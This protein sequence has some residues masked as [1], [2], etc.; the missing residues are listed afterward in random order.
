MRLCYKLL[1]G[2]LISVTGEKLQTVTPTK[3]NHWNFV[4]T[5]RRQNV[6]FGGEGEAKILGKKHT[7]KLT[8]V[9]HKKQKSNLGKWEKNYKKNY[10][11]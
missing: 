10:Q 5:S 8:K 1:Y 6:F 7:V 3:D 11:N 2:D 9:G 4:I